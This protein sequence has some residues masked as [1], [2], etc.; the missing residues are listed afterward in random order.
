M[1]NNYIKIKTGVVTNICKIVRYILDGSS[2]TIVFAD[3]TESITAGTFSDASITIGSLSASGSDIDDLAVVYSPCNGSLIYSLNYGYYWITPSTLR[4]N[5]T[6][7]E[8]GKPE[9]QAIINGQDFTKSSLETL[10]FEV[11]DDILFRSYLENEVL[12]SEQLFTYSSVIRDGL[13]R[14]FNNASSTLYITTAS[15]VYSVN[16]TLTTSS[17][18]TGIPSVT[19]IQ[20]PFKVAPSAQNTCLFFADNIL[21]TTTDLTTWNEKLF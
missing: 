15:N 20:K 1:V 4:N 7:I 9:L 18:L 2:A 6:D 8:T 14:S 17:V 19:V 13:S 11:K 21:Y 5:V 12:K 3:N 16:S 10:S